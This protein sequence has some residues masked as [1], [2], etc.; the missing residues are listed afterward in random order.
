MTQ[1]EEELDEEE[2]K[3]VT[4]EEIDDAYFDFSSISSEKKGRVTKSVI[5]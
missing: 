1:V 3:K 4:T 2:F 5:E